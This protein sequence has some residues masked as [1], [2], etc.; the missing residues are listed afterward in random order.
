MSQVLSHH[1][2]SPSTSPLHTTMMQSLVRLPTNKHQLFKSSVLLTSLMESWLKPR[3]D[4][5][6][7]TVARKYSLWVW[8]KLRGRTRLLRQ[9]CWLVCPRMLSWFKVRVPVLANNG[10]ENSRLGN[11]SSA[12]LSIPWKLTRLRNIKWPQ[13]QQMRRSHLISLIISQ[14]LHWLSIRCSSIDSAHKRTLKEKKGSKANS[15]HSRDSADLLH[16]RTRLQ[17]FRWTSSYLRFLSAVSSSLILHRVSGLLVT[18]T[19]RV[20]RI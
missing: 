13:R 16:R 19:C 17:G 10:V 6:R 5:Y 8:R 3:S 4:K 9:L 1:P 11:L 2:I 7:D 18:T 20:G 14:H 15:F 12:M